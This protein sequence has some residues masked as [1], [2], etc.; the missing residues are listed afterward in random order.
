M[1]ADRSRIVCAGWS[2]LAGALAAILV[3]LQA[4]AL[5]WLW[6]SWQPG[7]LAA[8]GL[9]AGYAGAV[10]I[11]YCAGRR[12]CA[13]LAGQERNVRT[14]LRRSGLAIVAAIGLPCGMSSGDDL[15]WALVLV[16]VLPLAVLPAAG[17]SA[18]LHLAVVAFERGTNFRR[19]LGAV[20]RLHR[21]ARRAE[22]D[23]AL[24]GLSFRDAR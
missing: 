24:A 15:R 19:A 8:L 2:M 23:A 4:M 16:V 9:L 14:P 1:N 7:A 5:C 21:E 17:M 22:W 18:G 13:M 11:G 12:V 3:A 6:W 20:R 10:M